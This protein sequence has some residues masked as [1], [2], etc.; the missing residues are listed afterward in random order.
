MRGKKKE[1][2]K[3]CELDT[4]KNSFSPLSKNKCIS[5]AVPFAGEGRHP[6]IEPLDFAFPLS[7]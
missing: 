5:A 6:Q 4:E 7:A 2:A 1:K 3:L